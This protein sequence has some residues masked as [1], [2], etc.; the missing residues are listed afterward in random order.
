MTVVHFDGFEHGVLSAAGG[1]L[2]SSI[3]G[4]P[5]IETGIV[6]TG[7]RSL[8]CDAASGAAWVSKPVGTVGIT[9][10]QFRFR[11]PS[12][13]PGGYSF[14]MGRIT[15]GVFNCFFHI[16][17]TTARTVR[18][19]LSDG[20]TTDTAVN[21]NYVLNQWHLICAKLDVTANPWTVVWQLDG[22]TQ[23]PVSLANTGGTVATTV[24][25]GP[26]AGAPSL[27]MYF[28]DWVA[29]TGSA[30]DYPMNKRVLGYSPQVRGT[31]LLDASPSSTFSQDDG[32][33]A[34]AMLSLE[35]T[36]FS[37]LNDVPL[38]ASFDYVSAQGVPGALNYLEYHFPDYTEAPEAVRVIEAVRQEPTAGGSVYTSKI[39]DDNGTSLTTM[40]SALDVNSATEVYKTAIAATKP[41]GGAWTNGAWDALKYRWGFTADATPQIRLYAVMI[42][43]LYGSLVATASIPWEIT[44]A[45]ATLRTLGDIPNDANIVRTWVLGRVPTVSDDIADGVSVGDTWIHNNQVWV[46]T[47]AAVGA[48]VWKEV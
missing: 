14:S 5:T 18:M 21:A 17:D 43:A 31:H 2:Y 11:I 39:T 42:E 15:S 12:T 46:C 34:V 44:A 25:L 28:D 3:V 23:D 32:T 30:G 27:L 10:V 48:A 1:G 19:L 22:V 16:G 7:N 35:S 40:Q 45:A 24:D 6:A 33:G 47:S 4:G 29:A 9:V 20:T 41:S 26:N 37:R 13:M 38:G 36:S 8:K